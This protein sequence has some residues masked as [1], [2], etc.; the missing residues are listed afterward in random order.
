VC[1]AFSNKVKSVYRKHRSCESGEIRSYSRG[2]GEVGEMA[3][4]EAQCAYCFESLCAKFEKRKPLSLDNVEH[5]WEAFNE[6]EIEDDSVNAEAVKDVA[7]PAAISRLKESNTSSV[8]STPSASSSTP[9][10]NTTASSVT[11][12][13]SNGKSALISVAQKLG[14][15][16]K[17]QTKRE[18]P[19]FVTYDTRTRSGRKELRG[20]IGTFEPHDLE[21]GLHSYALTS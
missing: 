4:T 17:T 18:Y 11:S 14:A 2:K 7:R 15:G 12:L 6:Q 1:P 9:S 13:S 16:Q 8:S 20:C 19:L 21:E 10:L 5:L 3:A